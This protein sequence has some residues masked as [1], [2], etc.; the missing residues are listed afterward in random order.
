V[1]RV[2]RY[3]WLSRVSSQESTAIGL[4]GAMAGSGRFV[5]LLLMAEDANLSG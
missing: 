3:H 1:R 2:R 5:A 4:V